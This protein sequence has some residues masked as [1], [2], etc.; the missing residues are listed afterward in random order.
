MSHSWPSTSTAKAALASPGPM[1]AA[2]SAPVTPRANVIVLPSG[3]VMV[4]LDAVMGADTGLLLWFE[5]LVQNLAIVKG[6]GAPKSRPT[7]E[8]LGSELA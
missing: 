7:L 2:T 8:Y 5:V 4:T 6:R 3:K 1:A